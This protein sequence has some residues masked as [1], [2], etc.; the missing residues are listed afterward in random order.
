MNSKLRNALL[1]W[2]VV[3]II[4]MTV[5]LFTCDV[6]NTKEIIRSAESAIIS[7]ALAGFAWYWLKGKIPM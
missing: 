7:G 2:I 1:T 4:I 6:I 3:A 5:N